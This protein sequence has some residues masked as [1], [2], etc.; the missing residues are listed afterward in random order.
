MKPND[1]NFYFCQAPLTLDG[2]PIRDF[3][4]GLLK[5][6]VGDRKHFEATLVSITSSHQRNELQKVNTRKGTFHWGFLT[7]SIHCSDEE[8]RVRSI[9]KFCCSCHDGWQKVEIGAVFRAIIVKFIMERGKILLQ[10]QF[11]VL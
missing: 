5:R 10:K 8:F 4:L 7:R 9:L 6:I 1:L 3:L 11:K 2:S